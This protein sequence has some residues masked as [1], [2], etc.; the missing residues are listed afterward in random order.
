MPG[1]I[2]FC[3]LDGTLI[4]GGQALSADNLEMLRDLRAGGVVVALASGRSLYSLS[5]V[6]T[7][8]MPF[9]YA[10]FSTGV[11]IMDWHKQE[12]L[13]RRELSESQVHQ[14]LDILQKEQIDTMIQAALPDNHHFQYRQFA[15][16]EESGTDFCRRIRLYQDFCRPLPPESWQGRASQLLAVLHPDDP[17]FLRILPRLQD[18][19]VIRATSP[20]DGHSIWL[21]IFA[22]GVSK[23]DA[24]SWLSG[25]LPNPPVTYALGNDHNDLDLL[26]W[27][28]YSLIAPDAPAEL[29]EKF[30][31]LNAEPACFLR[32]AAKTWQLP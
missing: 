26:E 1:K 22:P 23:S 9:D 3:D 15:A 13:L 6:V 24:A 32:Q 31:V 18:F 19:S 20:L 16:E 17:R 21:E 27:A 12:I 30:T 29:Q 7:R 28:Q 4:A 8:E 25:K 5:K 2:L 14:A 10:I 11:G